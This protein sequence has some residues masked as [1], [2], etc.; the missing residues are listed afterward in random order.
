[1][2]GPP[3][4]V[5]TV[6]ASSRL[7][8]YATVGA[9]SLLGALLAGRPALAAFGAPLVLLA[10]VGVCCYRPAALTLSSARLLPEQALAG[11]PLTLEVHVAVSPPAG[12]L[13]VVAN[14]TGPVEVTGHRA[15]RAAWTLTPGGPSAVRHRRLW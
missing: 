13:D 1:M 2:S 10:L 4:P 6:V 12:R 7:V 15:G 8:A 5:G 3:A 14:V 9:A 11:D